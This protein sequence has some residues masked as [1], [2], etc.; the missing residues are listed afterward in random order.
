MSATED[1]RLSHAPTCPAEV[2]LLAGGHH[3]PVHSLE[4]VWLIQEVVIYDGA[5][6]QPFLRERERDTNP[7][8][9]CKLTL[10]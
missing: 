1:A 3:V 10:V 8:A 9:V 4:D 6:I 2:Q 7:A 5:V